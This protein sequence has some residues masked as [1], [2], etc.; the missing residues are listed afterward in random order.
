MD[1]KILVT[2]VE[3]GAQII[4]S[5]SDIPMTKIVS[6]GRIVSASGKKRTASHWLSVI[7]KRVILESTRV[8]PNAMLT[9]VG[10]WTRSTRLQCQL[11]V[12]IVVVTVITREVITE[13][14]KREIV[15]VAGKREGG[16]L[17]RNE[18]SR[19]TSLSRS[20]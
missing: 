1:D 2:L 18:L 13:M 9:R 5:L 15:E 6:R 7:L 19:I 8:T 20:T 3:E 11:I 12:I 14:Q 10:K 4:I 17:L 16:T